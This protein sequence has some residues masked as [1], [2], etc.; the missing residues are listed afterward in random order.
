MIALPWRNLWRQPRRTLLTLLA[1]AFACLV[2]VFLLAVQVGTY[3]SM[4]DNSLSLFDGYAQVQAPGYRDDPDLRKSFAAAEAQTQELAGIPGVGAVAARAQTYALL[5]GASRSLAALVVGVE[6]DS[7]RRVSRIAATVR[8]GRY[9]AVPDAA[10]AVL[11][12]ALARNLGVKVGD[13]VTLLGSGRDGSVAADVFTVVGIS[14]SG[15]S[16][17]DRNLAEIPLARFQADFAMPGQVHA[18]VLS[19]ASL[20][21]VEAALPE[22]RRAAAAKGLAT[23]AWGDLEPGLRDAI[24]LDAGTSSFWYVALIVVVVAILL[25]TILMSILERTRE[26][27]ILLALG[28]RPVA[29]G[30]MVWLEIMLLVGLGLAAGIA[31]GAAGAGWYAVHG[32]ALPGAEGVFAQWGLPGLIYPR[33]TAFSLLAAPA[34]IAVCTALAGLYPFLRLNRLEPVAAM[35]TA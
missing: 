13:R 14:A 26:F 34:A 8:Q 29:V 15:V 9:L 17:L 22:V 24:R 27:G 2:M 10:E 12:E 21:A 23:L 31:L 7:E 32:L 18:L 3:A 5:T 6:P 1:I 11:G 30:R 4:E 28:M 20:A 25:N 16:E 35:R 19:G 33:L